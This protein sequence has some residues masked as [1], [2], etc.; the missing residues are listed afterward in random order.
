MQQGRDPQRLGRLGIFQQAG[1]FLDGLLLAGLDGFGAL[2]HLGGLVPHIALVGGALFAGLHPVGPDGG[3]PGR[4]FQTPDVPA[5]PFILGLF[6]GLP[7][8]EVGKPGGKVPALDLDAGPVEGEDVVD[9]AVQE[10]PVVGDED[11]A[12][13]FL[14]VGRHHGPRPG[15]EVV[16]GLVDEQ[17]VPLVQKQ[18]GQQDF[19][20][21]PVGEAAEGPLQHV[22]P[23][24]EQ[25]EL[26]FQLPAVRA[27]ADAAQHLPGGAVR[28]GDGVGEIVE[29]DRGADGAAVFVLPPQQPEKGGLAAPVAADEAQFPA[30]V[31]PEADVFKNGVIAGRIRKTQVFDLDQCHGAPLLCTKTGRRHSPAAVR[32]QSSPAARRRR[33][34]ALLPMRQKGDGMGHFL[35]AGAMR[36]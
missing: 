27:G 32:A 22:G 6:Q 21:L 25:G 9:A 8:L 4:L 24:R 3:P 11:E 5:Q 26:P 14:Q 2:H 29:R 33:T 15:V 17:K 16:G 28:V 1:L 19:G 31:Q 30:G 12:L 36:P 23:D 34:G 18:A 35:Q 20:L 13:L 10:T 7:L